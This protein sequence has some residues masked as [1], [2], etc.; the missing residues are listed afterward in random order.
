[1]K[2]IVYKST[3]SWYIVKTEQGQTLNARI[4]G[5]FKIDEITSTNP[6][7]VGD[8]VNI[9]MENDAEQTAV[10]SQIYDRKNYIVR[11]TPHH[12]K[13]RHIVASNLD[14]LLLFATLKEPRTSQGF[15]DRFLVAA[16]AFHIPAVIVFNKADL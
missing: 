10:I 13:Q 5:I 1:M 9:E 6:I 15:V 12:N 2:A 8:E 7:A 14:Q 4:K 3:G 11:S 16:E